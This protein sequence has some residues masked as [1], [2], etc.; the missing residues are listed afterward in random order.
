[1]QRGPKNGRSIT[2]VLTHKGW[3]F[4]ESEIAGVPSSSAG[5]TDEPEP[6]PEPKRKNKPA[7]PRS[8]EEKRQL[9]LDYLRRNG[10]APKQQVQEETNI[11]ESSMKRVFEVMKRQGDIQV[12]K[13]TDPTVPR[14]YHVE[15]S[16]PGTGSTPE[17]GSSARCC[18]CE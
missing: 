10:P 12:R 15:L 13:V 8:I 14:G 1:M 9:I 7:D 6:E 18:A 4:Y 3:R 11:S 17:R 2:H 16:V 5:E